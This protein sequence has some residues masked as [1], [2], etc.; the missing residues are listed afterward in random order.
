MKKLSILFLLFAVLLNAQ[1]LTSTELSIINEGDVNS[2]LPI[3]QTTDAH[4]HKTLLSLSSE[5]NPTDPNTAV[6]VKE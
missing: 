6:L 1:K 5:I 4:Q 3:Y 2:A